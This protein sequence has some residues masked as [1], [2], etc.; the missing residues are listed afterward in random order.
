MNYAILALGVLCLTLLAMIFS[1]LRSHAS[2]TA[3]RA[4]A[5]ERT[6]QSM[7]DRI[8][9]PSRLP[10]RDGSVDYVIPE[11]EPDEWAQVG[12]IS[13]NDDYGLED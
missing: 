8:Q 9:A 6:L 10:V 2:E 4:A 1:I 3:D 13:I 12:Q 7:A 5:Y 11:R